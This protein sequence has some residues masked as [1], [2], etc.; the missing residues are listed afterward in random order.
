MDKTFD[1]YM[2]LDITKN[3]QG[4][5]LRTQRGSKSGFLRK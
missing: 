1:K 2:K 5:G 4:T 3:F